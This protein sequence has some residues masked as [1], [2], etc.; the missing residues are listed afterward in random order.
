MENKRVFFAFQ[1][2]PPYDKLAKYV[3]IVKQRIHLLGVQLESFKTDQERIGNSL[4]LYEIKKSQ[5]KG[6]DYFQQKHYHDLEMEARAADYLREI[7]EEKRKALSSAL[8]SLRELNLKISDLEPS[9]QEKA[10][11]FEIEIIQGSKNELTDSLQKLSCTLFGQDTKQDTQ[12]YNLNKIAYNWNMSICKWNETTEKLSN[13]MSVTEKMWRIRS[14]TKNQLIEE[15]DAAI[16]ESLEDLNHAMFGDSKLFEFLENSFDSDGNRKYSKA[17]I[18][19]EFKYRVIRLMEIRDRL[20]PLPEDQKQIA[21][22]LCNQTM[23]LYRPDH[24]KDETINALY[25]IN[26]KVYNADRLF[27][28][29]SL[30]N[31]NPENVADNENGLS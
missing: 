11:T 26:A 30:Q 31:A 25:D 28:K 2:E 12:D 15:Y 7:Y 1:P 17:S 5:Q 18:L 19:N 22:E 24:R 21:E 6:L 29:S 10:S 27:R 13:L 16:K 8:D 3:K 23:Q 14:Q 9:I 4:I 20:M